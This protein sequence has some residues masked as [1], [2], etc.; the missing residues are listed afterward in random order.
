MALTLAE[1]SKLSNDVLLKGVV[2]TI[3]KVG[4]LLQKCPSIC[5]MEINPLVVLPKGGLLAVDAVL[6]VDN[7]ASDFYTVVEVYT[8]DRPGLL[9]RVT[10]KVF[11][12]V[13]IEAERQAYDVRLSFPLLYGDA[14]LQVVGEGKHVTVLYL[15]QLL[16]LL[17]MPAFGLVVV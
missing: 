11:E 6:E 10:K 5:D 12:I 3:V 1:A 17:D 15:P 8:H 4:T 14:V 2:E 16:A 9:Y 7:S 13:L